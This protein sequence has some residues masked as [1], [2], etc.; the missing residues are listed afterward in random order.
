M[1]QLKD[2]K[3][4]Y[5]SGEETVQA[6]KG[7]SLN[8]RKSEFVSILGQSGCGKTTLL[9]LIGGL[10]Q[11]TSGNLK[12]NGRSTKDFKARDWDTYRNHSIGFVFQSYNLIPHQTVLSN[13]ELA[14]TLTGVSREERK[15]RAI[16]VLNEVGL[17][18]QIH[19]KPNQMSGGQ[20]QRVA[21]ARALIND[22]DILLADEPTGALDSATSVQIME[23]LK[24]ISKDK[25]VI[26]VTHNPDIAQ[27][28]ST[29][30]IRLLDGK[31][32][33]DSNPYL[34]DEAKQIESIEQGAVGK[35]TSMSFLT[36]L[37]LS[38]NNLVT[39][40]GRTILT[41]FAGSIGIIGIAL[42]MS[43][44]NGVQ[45]Y[46]SRVE[47]DTLSTYPLMIEDSSVDMSVMMEALTSMSSNKKAY[48][49]GK[50]HS[51]PLMNDILETMS[52]KQTSNNL[53]AFREYL[54]NE[55]QV[56]HECSNA[57]QYGYDLPLNI[58]NADSE[59]GLIRTSPNQVFDTI[60]MGESYEMQSQFLSSS[61]N[62]Y[63]IWQEMMNNEELLH[64]QYDLVDGRWPEKYNEVVLMVDENHTVSDYTLYSLGLFDQQEMKEN[65]N[66]LLTGEDMKTDAEAA[67]TYED[68]LNMKFKL[69]LNTDYYVKENGIWIDKSEDEEY[70]KELADKG[71]E[72]SIVGIVEPNEET[73]MVSITGGIGYTSELKKHVIETINQTEIAKE[74]LANPNLNVLTGLEFATG[75]AANAQFDY[76]SLTEEQ[77][78]QMAALSE[79][80]LAQL[81]MNYQQ[82]AQATY[83]ENLKTLGIIDLEQPNSINIYPK[84]FESKEK[85]S[86]AINEYNKKQQKE[87][88]EEDVISY[89]DMVAAMMSSVT[90]IIDIVSYVL[91]AFV[92]VSLIVSSIMIGIITYISVL[93]RTKEIGILRSIGAS[94][95]DI[96][97]VFNAETLIIG[98]F[99]GLLGVV[100]TVLLDLPVSAV[101]KSK[102][103]VSNIASLPLLGGLLLVVISTCLTMIAGLIPAKVASKK[104]PVEAL[105][106][107]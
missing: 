32:T 93:E 105:R 19:K 71:E 41:A 65:V 99:A 25:L 37:T 49:D 42:I 80:E 61:M 101:V 54:E 35:K 20:M 22:P 28:Y 47:E 57:I 68:L 1:L 51:T 12:I 31:V 62:V 94:K 95:R 13:V 104:D 52:T 81:M 60:G 92:S 11:Y 63:E 45:N 43:L 72:I 44:S 5:R 29:R 102:L 27:E 69:V 75:D 6:L 36:A 98:L 15:K 39:K 67:Y 26:M 74:Q 16:E 103:G 4:D 90:S 48:N 79:E 17:G 73:V 40:K 21:I 76:N 7:I 18:D 86:D 64:S 107:E 97:R 87:G 34:L 85:I 8:F 84:D 30:I 96:S 46:I 9:N 83:E 14:L 23:I 55:D 10:D 3:K 2:I 88:R 91:M 58:Y 56:I 82:N 59:Y 38:L 70:V 50:I 89:N 106:S 33:D 100:V 24:K 78:A 66:A 77:K 53:E